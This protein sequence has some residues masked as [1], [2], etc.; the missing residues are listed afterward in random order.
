MTQATDNAGGQFAL[1]ETIAFVRD[2][3]HC[4]AKIPAG[5]SGEVIDVDPETDDL[6]VHLHRIFPELAH[7]G[8][9]IWIPREKFGAIDRFTRAVAS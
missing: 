5:T 7:T 1:G 4:L 8:N 9:T 6:V 3:V 2:S